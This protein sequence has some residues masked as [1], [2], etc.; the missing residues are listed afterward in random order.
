M[1]GSMLLLAFSLVVVMGFRTK[2]LLAQ[3]IFRRRRRH[4][5]VD[6]TVLDASIICDCRSA[7]TTFVQPIPFRLG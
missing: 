3:S 1:N 4:E 2:K 5:A 7:C 6:E